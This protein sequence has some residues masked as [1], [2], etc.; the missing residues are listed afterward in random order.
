M[1]GIVF[2][3]AEVVCVADNM[4]MDSL[5]A[6]GFVIGLDCMKLWGEGQFYPQEGR[7]VFPASPTPL[8]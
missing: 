3:T 6:G 5:L 1:G 2:R 8:P 4:V 7:I